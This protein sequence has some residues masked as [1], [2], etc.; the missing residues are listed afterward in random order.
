MPTISLTSPTALTVIT[1]GLHATNYAALQSLL[2][3]NLDNANI[4]PTAAMAVAKLA[5]GSNGQTLQTV[6]G[7]PTW[8]ATAS[9]GY[10]TSFPGSP[11]DGQE[12]V[13]V[14]S[15][16][17]PTYQWAFRYNSGSSNSSKWEFI[18]GL[19]V[20]IE[21]AT[22]QSTASATYTD[23]ATVG[24]DF[25][26][27]RAGD[28]L[29]AV[30]CHFASTD[31]VGSFMSYAV[32]ATAANDTWGAG[33]AIPSAGASAAQSAM[34]RWNAIAASTLIRAR[35]RTPTLATN[36]AARQLIVAPYRLA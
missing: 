36:F 33:E 24:P 6:A 19:P 20:V 27:P 14:D 30:G 11:T 3:G 29:I 9:T 16:T 2:N 18:G 34:K 17:A 5:A 28:W 26:T 35:Y 32:G 1:A 31:N 23:L 4:S 13:L 12:Y 10:G 21:V 25:T 7:V 22:Q 8:A 15:T